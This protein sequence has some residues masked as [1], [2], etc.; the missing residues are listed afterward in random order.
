MMVRWLLAPRQSAAIV[1]RRFRQAR[2][3]AR[4]CV[5]CFDKAIVESVL[6]YNL[7]NLWRRLV[8]P[9]KIEN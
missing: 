1:R 9:K 4:T 5:A 6:A 7:G 2:S 8:L 3:E